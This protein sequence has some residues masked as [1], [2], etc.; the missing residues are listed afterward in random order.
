MNCLYLFAETPEYL[1]E[2][3]LVKYSAFG[4]NRYGVSATAAI[5]DYAN[6]LI[7]DWLLKPTVI[8][9][10]NDNG[11]NTETTAPLLYSICNRALLEELIA[12]TPEIN[13]DRIRALGMV[14][15]LRQEKIILYKGDISSNRKER[16]PSSY[17]GND[18]FFTDNYDNR[19]G[20][21]L[22]K[23]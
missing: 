15:L 11:E 13:V 20:I 1:R 23:T 8:Q 7:R 10:T 18:K 6:N 14:M 17:I 16:I 9:T 12:Y 19:F 4:S 21:D 5:N 3:Q 2:K 22:I